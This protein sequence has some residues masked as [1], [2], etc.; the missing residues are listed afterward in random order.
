MLRVLRTMRVRL[1][2]LLLGYIYGQVMT[3]DP[4]YKQIGAV[5]KAR[6]KTLG[7][8]QEDS[9]RPDWG[10]R[11]DRWPTSKL[12]DRVFWSTNFISI[13]AKLDLSLLICCRHPSTDHFGPD[14]LSCRYRLT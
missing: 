1:T 8:K 6:R 13:A 10:F 14:G 4:M 5:I 7:M 3:P 11:E 9:G 2:F 12:D